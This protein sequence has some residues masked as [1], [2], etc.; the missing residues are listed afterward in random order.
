VGGDTSPGCGGGGVGDETSPGVGGTVGGER[1][2]QARMKVTD[3]SASS[4][5]HLQWDGD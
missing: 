2:S 5:N 4:R 3:V 1:P